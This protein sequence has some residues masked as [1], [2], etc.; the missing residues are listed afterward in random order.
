MRTFSVQVIQ[1]SDNVLINAGFLSDGKSLILVVVH[2]YR[3]SLTYCSLGCAFGSLKLTIQTTRTN[4]ELLAGLTWFMLERQ[5]LSAK[6]PLKHPAF[7]LEMFRYSPLIASDAFISVA[8]HPI[9]YLEFQSIL[10]WRGIF[11]DLSELF[12]ARIRVEFLPGS[13]P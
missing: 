2:I 6:E 9:G 8:P 3:L 7:R 5:N 13:S 11:I 1:L 12:T 4:P 10:Y